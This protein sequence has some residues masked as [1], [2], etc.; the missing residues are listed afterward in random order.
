VKLGEMSENSSFKQQTLLLRQNK[1]ISGNFLKNE[2]L[3][4]KEGNYY[5]TWNEFHHRIYLKI[6]Y[7]NSVKLNRQISMTI[8]DVFFQVEMTAAAVSQ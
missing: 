4:S 8:C 5:S 7:K 3:H 2:L 1:L 6:C